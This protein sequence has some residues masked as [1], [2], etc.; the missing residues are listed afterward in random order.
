MTSY[1]FIQY[2]YD[3]II[4]IYMHTYAYIYPICEPWCLYTYP[5][6]WVICMANVGNYS[7]TMGET[8]WPTL[9]TSS[10]LIV[11]ILF[12]IP[13]NFMRFHVVFEFKGSKQPIW[14]GTKPTIPDISRIIALSLAMIILIECIAVTIND[15]R[16]FMVDTLQE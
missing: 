13:V 7:S 16:L 3:C 15:Y 12:G 8:W 6:N 10:L 5:Q 9:P 14:G 1:D 11:E 2:V 4:Y